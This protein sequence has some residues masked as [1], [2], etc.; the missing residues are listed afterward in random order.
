MTKIMNLAEFRSNFFRIKRALPWLDPC[1][2]PQEPQA[3]L[4]YSA[5]LNTDYIRSIE[6]SPLLEPESENPQIIRLNTKTYELNQLGG[7]LDK[8]EINKIPL[9]VLHTQIDFEAI[10]KFA[11]ERPGMNIIIESG[12]RKLIYHYGKILPLLKKCSNIY[13]CSYNFC[14]WLGHEKIVNEGLSRRLL[15]GSHMPLF[16]AD[17]SMGPI[18]MGDFSWKTKCDLAGNNLRS[19]LNIK[20]VFPSEIKLNLPE[21]FIIDAHAHNQQ[22]GDSVNGFPTPDMEFTPSDWVS[23]MDGYVCEKLLLIPSEA[24]FFNQSGEALSKELRSFAPDRFAYM[25]LFNPRLAD[26]QYL[27]KL[28]KSL[29]NPDCIGIKIHPSTHKVEGGDARY[30][31]IFKIAEEYNKPIMTHSWDVSD[32]NPVQ[33]MSH[34]DQFRTHLKKHHKMPFVLGHAGGRPGAFEATVKLCKEFDNV[35]VDFAGDYYH[36]GVIDAFASAIGAERIL[37]ASDVN[38]FDPRCNLGMFLGTNINDDDL[39]KMLRTNALK[40]YSGR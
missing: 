37:F 38:W 11:M 7:L 2:Y 25:E 15:Y 34:P 31:I 4:E 18:I 17:V 24:L 26:E 8:M 29:L 14:N 32:Y 1:V 12:N 6:A 21:P 20:P 9:A 33:Y 22:R 23:F 13:L 19:L 35:Y 39:L 40:V 27:Q 36:N 10:E 5:Q 16:S 30:E 28:K 3:F